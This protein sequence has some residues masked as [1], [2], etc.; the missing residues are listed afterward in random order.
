MKTKIQI[1]AMLA[2]LIGTASCTSCRVNTWKVSVATAEEQRDLRG[3]ERIELLGSLDVRYQQ[4]DSFSV[5]VKAPSKYLDDVE[6]RVDSNR[7]IVRMKGDG[8]VIHFGVSDGDQV[9]VYVTSPD[10]IG[11]DLRGS[12]DF[13]CENHLDTDQ[14]DIRLN[15]SGDIDF[16]DVICDAVNVEVV[17]SGD[18]KVKNIET[19]A[20]N[21]SL[22]GSGDIKMAFQRS[23]K[24]NVSVVGSGDIELSGEVH[25]MEQTKRGSGDI[26]TGK[27]IV[28]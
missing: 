4:A 8:K 20:A 25:A 13:S 9:T 22:V 18:V 28:R 10:L 6:T 15:G 21:L 16:D 24:V 1:L 17:G 27:L 7:L 14:L 11:V 26:E 5:V 23:G 12:G 19:Q 3:F 2:V